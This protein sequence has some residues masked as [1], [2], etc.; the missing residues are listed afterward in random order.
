MNDL[1][2][3]AKRKAAWLMTR[4][5]MSFSDAYQLYGKYIEN[6]GDSASVFRFDAVKKGKVIRTVT[7]EA[8]T[9]RR[10]EV[11]VS[12][13]ALVEGDTYDVALIRLRMTDQNGNPLPCYQGFV[14][15]ELQGDIAVI[16]PQAA[17][18]I[19][20]M[21]GLYIRTLG[22]TGDASVTLIPD[23]CEPVTIHFTI[24]DSSR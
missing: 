13:T 19:G 14:K 11:K 1:S 10:L 15:L 18:I 2:L 20:G 7:K 12:H 8:F 4:Y 6:W 5:R 24:I 3:N 23:G 9:Q 16:G 22:K 21:G 17:P